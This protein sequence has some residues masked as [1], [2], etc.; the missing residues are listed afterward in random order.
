MLPVP[1]PPGRA[2]VQP[3]PPVSTVSASSEG[4]PCVA[5]VQRVGTWWK[6]PLWLPGAGAA[7][8]FA[9]R[10]LS[11]VRAAGFYGCSFCS[12][13]RLFYG[14]CV[15]AATPQMGQAFESLRGSQW[16]AVGT[17][18]ARE[19]KG[20]GREVGTW[21]SQGPGG[22]PREVLVSS[23]HFPWELSLILREGMTALT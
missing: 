11:A 18:A 22:P 19:R 10:W 9:A 2:R 5:L 17:R 15:P 4:L 6:H 3:W 20:L 14:R 13:S 21:S 8:G 1:P 12:T 7:G 23:G 16:H